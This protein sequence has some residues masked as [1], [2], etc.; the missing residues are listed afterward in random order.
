M[1]I[2]R[3][4]LDWAV[5][6][7][8]PKKSGETNSSAPIGAYHPNAPKSSNKSSPSANNATTE[9]V[10]EETIK[11]ESKGGIRLLSAKWLE[12]KDGFEFNKECWLEVKAEIKDKSANKKVEVSLAVEYK[13]QAEDLKFT[14]SGELDANGY[15]K[16]KV[17]LYYSDCYFDDLSNDPSAECLYFCKAKV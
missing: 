14:A 12:G 6:G 17:V 10:G 15:V 11:A 4:D 3:E 7:V 16:I 13:D 8:T 5:W 2:S 1:S 9:D